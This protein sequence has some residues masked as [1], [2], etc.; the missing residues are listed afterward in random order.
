MDTQPCEVMPQTERGT[1]AAFEMVCETTGSLRG[2]S[3]PLAA[4]RAA[5]GAREG[6]KTRPGADGWDR[7]VE[8]W[9]EPGDATR[10]WRAVKIT[11][12]ER[13]GLAE[14]DV[15]GEQRMRTEEAMERLGV[16]G[17]DLWVPWGKGDDPVHCSTVDFDSDFQYL[18]DAVSEEVLRDAVRREGVPGLSMGGY[19]IE[20]SVS[21]EHEEGQSLDFWV[22]LGSRVFHSCG[23][24]SAGLELTPMAIPVMK[25]VEPYQRSELNVPEMQR[26]LLLKSKMAF[27]DLTVGTHDLKT[28]MSGGFDKL[29]RDFQ[30]L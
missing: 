3:G 1:T 12:A 17:K 19:G 23:L 5:Q 24:A 26:E 6:G 21:L 27:D 22:S 11:M 29:L 30:E 25:V 15:Q 13:L 2:C 8:M 14:P 7:V 4:P 28:Y 20:P 16:A 10:P 18:H 9:L